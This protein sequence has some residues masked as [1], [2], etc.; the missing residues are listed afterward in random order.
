MSRDAARHAVW[1]GLTLRDLLAASM[2]D[3]SDRDVLIDIGVDGKATGF[4]PRTLD[5]IAT[6]IARRFAT[7]GAK[8]GDPI[9]IALPNGA[10][11]F[12]ALIGALG[13]GLKPCLVPPTLDDA[14]IAL[15]LQRLKPR[16]LVSAALPGFD[17]LQRFVTEARRLAM[18]LYIWNFGP[19]DNDHAAP[20]SD[21]LDGQAPQRMLP[22]HPPHAGDG[23]ILT[24]T[25][26]G[27]GPEPVEH[28]QDALLAQAVL[29]RMAE[30]TAPAARIVSAVS[31]ATQAGLV[32]GPLRA[33]LSGAQLT[34]IAD[35]SASAMR[36]AAAQGAAE[37][38]LPQS[39]AARLRECGLH[40]D[41][42]PVTTLYRAGAQWHNPA[43]QRGFIA[44]GEALTLPLMRHG[45]ALGPG[46]L[47]ALT[48]DGPLHFASLETNSD[49]TIAI[50]SP[51]A[52]LL[53][54]GASAC[55]SLL[56]TLA[57][58]G[59]FARFVNNPWEKRRA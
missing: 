24:M 19:G 40:G 30:R 9:V 4:K 59:R 2:V 56:A 27:N 44:F 23:S 46:A 7:A 11:A 52:G 25:D 42:G 18:P 51:L 16:A 22:L 1:K 20:L 31:I 48:A 13:A 28:R 32:L 57:P 47:G 8:Q 37:F 5:H 12:L 3:R 33:L 58:D 29:A 17:P 21:L 43:D 55:P 14:Q 54:D 39:L 34:L 10:S 53:P 36:L 15:L 41:N 35:P 6:R 45:K 50:A 49:G 26:L 38:V